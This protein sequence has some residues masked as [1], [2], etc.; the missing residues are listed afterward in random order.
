VR[1]FRRHRSF[2]A[3]FVLQISQTCGWILTFAEKLAGCPEVQIQARLVS[4]EK[5]FQGARDAPPL[6]RRSS[7]IEDHTS[8]V[9]D[10]NGVGIATIKAGLDVEFI[11]LVITI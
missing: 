1:V 3:P 8:F 11:A 6:D 2:V 5:D 4:A 7:P 10:Q 9:R